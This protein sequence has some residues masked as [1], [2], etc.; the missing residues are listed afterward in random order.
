MKLTADLIANSP[1]YIN[2]IKEYELDL[3]G[4]HI[5][6][7]ENLGATRN[8]YDAL[9]LCNNT[10][11]V[12]GNFPELTRLQS[13]YIA[14]NRISLIEAD[15]AQTLPHLRTLVLTDNQIQNLVD[16]EPLGQ[17]EMLENLSIMSNPVMAKPHARLWCIWRFK[18]L[19]VLN[20]ERVLLKEK[21]E[22]KELFETSGQLTALAQGI[23]AMEQSKVEN[24]FVPGEGLE[25]KEVVDQAKQQSIAELKA[26]IR[27]EMA[28]VA[29]MEEFI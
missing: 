13:L 24:T 5:T 10:I 27:E 2:A 29:A 1:T 26:R 21:Q 15:L 9:N 8:L 20:F 25:T 3:S 19:K 17:L 7:I 12:V 4:N 6:M 22:A 11:R 23:L 14:D 18:S 28:Q 16:L